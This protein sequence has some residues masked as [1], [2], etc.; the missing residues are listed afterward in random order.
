MEDLKRNAKKVAEGV[1]SHWPKKLTRG[2]WGQGVK[3]AVLSP[4]EK[5]VAAVVAVAPPPPPPK[6]F[7]FF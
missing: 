4:A 3:R 2:G 1:R 7:G 5:P 6:K